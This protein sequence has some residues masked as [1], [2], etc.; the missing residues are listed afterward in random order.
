MKYQNR[1]ED[2]LL[3]GNSGWRNFG[4]GF[5]KASG[6]SLDAMIFQYNHLN[7][8]MGLMEQQ[9]Q[10]AYKPRKKGDQEIPV[11]K[12]TA[13]EQPP[14]AV[15]IAPETDLIRQVNGKITMEIMRW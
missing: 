9:F 5:E 4:G 10:I 12:L 2:R 1:S 13:P 7:L 15:I 6:H 11:L 14:M 3:L 8:P